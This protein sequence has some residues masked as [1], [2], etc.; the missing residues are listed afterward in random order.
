MLSAL[1]KCVSVSF[2]HISHI[3][4]FAVAAVVTLPPGN[5]FS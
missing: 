4:V 3:S 5:L 1:D 2:Y